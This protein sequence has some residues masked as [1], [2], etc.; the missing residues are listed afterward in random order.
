[1]YAHGNEPPPSAL[2]VRPDLPREFDDVIERAMAKNPDHRYPSAGDLGRA[3]GAAA[4][5]QP[6]AAHERSVATG[7]AAP[8]AVAATAAHPAAA[9]TAPGSAPV[10]AQA[11]S[12]APATQ[13][14]GGGAKPSRI[15]LIAVAAAIVVALIVVLAI[16]LGS[17]GGGGGGGNDKSTAQQ[18]GAGTG[19]AR[20][21]KSK[22][23]YDAQA[24]GIIG[25]VDTSLAE[26]QLAAGLPRRPRVRTRVS[27]NLA[28]TQTELSAAADQLAGLKP[29]ADATAAHKGVTAVLRS[30]ARSLGQARAATDAGNPA[31]FRAAAVRYRAARTEG[32]K[33]RAKFE[34]LG[35]RRLGGIGQASP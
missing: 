28:A 21:S 18:S 19:T 23:K 27:S 1:M 15:G 13:P 17:G 5:C 29:P 22:A 33:V 3:A 7:S 35:Y 11:Q 9:A 6:A 16:A 12:P 30:L 4:Q 25:G 24:A 31:A 34:R 26:Q 10:T 8:T 20:Q 14:P 2:A 32:D